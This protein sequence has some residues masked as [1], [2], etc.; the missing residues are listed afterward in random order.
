MFVLLW[1]QLV[2]FRSGRLPTRSQVW[3][4]WLSA[5]GALALCLLAT[6]SALAVPP[7]TMSIWR[8]QVRFITANVDDAGTDS[9][10]WI[11]LNGSNRTYIDSGRDDRERGQDETYELLLDNVHT[12][13]DLDYFR[14]EKDGD[15]GWAISRML[16]IVNNVPIYDESFSSALWLDNEGG[17][18]RIRFIDDQFMRPRSQWANYVVPARPSVVPVGDMNARVESLHGDFTTLTSNLSLRETG[19][20]DASL[21]AIDI[22]TWQVHV[23]LAEKNILLIGQD[24]DV[25]FHLKVGCTAGSP[26]FTVSNVNASSSFEYY[27]EDTR[28]QAVDFVNG[29]FK[30][31]LNDMM[32]GFHYVLQCPTIALAP[33]GDL[34]LGSRFNLGD[35]VRAN[36][37]NAGAV[38][39]RVDTG[40]GIKT[41]TPSD[42]T[43]TVVS[44]LKSD[45]KAQLS[46]ELPAAIVAY[47]VLVEV[48]PLDASEPPKDGKT[49][50]SAS[51][52]TLSKN[53]SRTIKADLKKRGD[54]TSLLTFTDVLVAGQAVEYTLHLVYQPKGEGRGSIETVIQPLDPESQKLITPLKS[55]TSFSFKEGVVIPEGTSTTASH[56]VDDKPVWKEPKPA[57]AR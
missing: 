41:S 43:A 31:L 1:S 11:Q 5:L 49:L 46:F 52:S 32:K 57:D 54:D 15:D 30:V 40:D 29:D 44:R 22:N 4:A 34:H 28:G 26:T 23:D 35:Y 10:V 21:N 16:L 47:D 19:H 51:R 14:I 42:Y 8:A 45:T 2:Q 12:L 27:T 37:Q 3:S 39:L 56:Y 38:A 13:A 24:I 53:A 7:N 55:T 33:N 36:L 18:S 6:S 20:G 9:S 50:S 17:A 48:R 25:D